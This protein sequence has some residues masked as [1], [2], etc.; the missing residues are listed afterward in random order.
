M[1]SDNFER[2]VNSIKFDLLLCI[3]DGF[4]NF[5][6]RGPVDD[7]VIKHYSVELKRKKKFSLSKNL[8]AVIIFQS[9]ELKKS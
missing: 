4:V 6:L 1:I 7:A 5:V 3:D 9:V 2:K 8:K